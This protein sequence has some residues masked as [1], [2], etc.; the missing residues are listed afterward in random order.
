MFVAIGA[1]CSFGFLAAHEPLDGALA[2]RI[3]YGVAIILC[4][5][6]AL[7]LFRGGREKS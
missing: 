2:W 7:R 5:Y 1:F 3:G 4:I 6:C